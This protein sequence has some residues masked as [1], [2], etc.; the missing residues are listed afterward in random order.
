MLKQCVAP[1][2]LVRRWRHRETSAPAAAAGLRARATR[3]QTRPCTHLLPKATPRVPRSQLANFF[4]VRARGLAACR[5]RATAAPCRGRLCRRLR[6]RSP[7]QRRDSAG[8][9]RLPWRS[10][11]RHLRTSVLIVTRLWGTAASCAG[12]TSAGAASC[13]VYHPDSVVH[14]LNTAHGAI[15]T[16]LAPPPGAVLRGSG[17]AGARA[18][19]RALSWSRHGPAL[20]HL[21][22]G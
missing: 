9:R 20:V 16:L 1:T 21:R 6:L 18:L 3:C 19:T 7:K 10:A 11:P 17:T 14:T 15:V 2:R 12:C 5:Q 4:P 22:A 13:M 8:V